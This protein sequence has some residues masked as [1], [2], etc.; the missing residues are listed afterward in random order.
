MLQFILGPC[1]IESEMM[2]LETAG[3][4][5]EILSFPFIF[6]S[7]FDKANR[8]SIHSFRGVGIKKGLKILERVKRE[9]GL[10]VTTDIHLPEQAEEV[11]LV[12]DILQIP[13]FIC[14]QTDL[15]VA[16]G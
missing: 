14:R 8:S 7:S 2:I 11:A 3:R 12:C 9:F 6:K 1:V 16:A 13:A 4:L 15:L 10:P 5:L